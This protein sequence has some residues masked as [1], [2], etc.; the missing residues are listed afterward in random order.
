MVRLKEK[1]IEKGFSAINTFNSSMVRLK[2]CSCTT[3][4]PLDPTFN[5]SM[6]R[7]KDDNDKHNISGTVPFQFQYGAIKG[8]PRLKW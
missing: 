6:V 1:E 2:V 3:F 4:G 5:S 8:M 7:L